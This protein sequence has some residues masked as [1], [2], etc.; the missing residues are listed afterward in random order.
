MSSKP[1]PQITAAAD[2]LDRPIEGAKAIAEVLNLFDDDG[3]PDTR[4]AYW[5]CEN[6][7]VDV[8]KRGR[9]WWS[10]PR[11]LLNPD[12]QPREKSEAAE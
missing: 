7:Q 4:R 2:Y 12:F 6:G 10:T 3:D 8:S 5:V 1:R 9:K 11:R